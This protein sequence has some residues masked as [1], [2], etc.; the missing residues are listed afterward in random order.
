MRSKKQSDADDV[1]TMVEDFP[2]VPPAETSESQAK[3]DKFNAALESMIDVKFAEIMKGRADAD[4]F[5]TY[6]DGQIL[7]T[8]VRNVFKSALGSTPPQVE[9]ACKLSEALLA[10]T[11]E[12]TQQLIKAAIGIGGGATG[13]VMIL[14]GIGAALGW[15][16]GVIASVTAV[17]IGFSF[18]GPLVWILAGITLAGI[19]AYFAVTSDRVSDTERFMIVLKAATARAVDAIWQQNEAALSGAM[20]N[21]PGA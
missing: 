21:K 5:L 18:L 6:V 13:I 8:A 20:G 16:A 11:S 17:F 15:G 10:P 7:T 2:K 3:R 4:R 1:N 19:A 14:T 9:T 12:E